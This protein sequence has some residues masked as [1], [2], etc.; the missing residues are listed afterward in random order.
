MKKL[1]TSLFLLTLISLTGCKA[2]TKIS[3][4]KN[5]YVV[6]TR[7][8]PQLKPILLAAEELKMEDAHKFGEFHI[9]VCGQTVSELT[10][11]EAMEEFMKQVTDIGVKMN[12]CGFSL[13]KFKVNTEELPDGIKVVENGIL[14]NLQLQKKGYIS[15]EL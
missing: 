6:L 10:N 14:H 8:L 5:N 1:F 9:V 12:A 2:Q 13:K 3:S 11:P 15:L 7:K 4:K